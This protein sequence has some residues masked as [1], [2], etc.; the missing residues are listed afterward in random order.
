MSGGEFEEQK[1]INALID[2]NEIESVFPSGSSDYTSI[3]MKSGNCYWTPM[4]LQQV[5]RILDP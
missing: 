5:H 3:C 4:S 2:L 1:E